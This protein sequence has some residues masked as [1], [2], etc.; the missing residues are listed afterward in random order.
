MQG[1]IKKLSQNGFGFIEREGEEKDL[2][3][4]ANNLEGVDFDSLREG[5]EVSFEVEDSEKGPR[6]INIAKA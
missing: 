1:K 6:A 5:E 4:H 3:F 2:F